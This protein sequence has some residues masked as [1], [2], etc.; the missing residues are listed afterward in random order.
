MIDRS[1]RDKLA[2]L[3]RRLAAGRITT[4]Q[5]ADECEDICCSSEDSAILG[6]LSSGIMQIPWSYWPRRLRNKHRLSDEV[7]HRIAIAVVFLHSECEYEW[8]E[9]TMGGDCLLLAAF[10]LLLVLGAF[11]T[12]FWQLGQVSVFVAVAC[13]ALAVY[14]FYFSNIRIE[15]AR[16]RWLANCKQVGDFD[17]WPFF[18]SSDLERARTPPRFLMG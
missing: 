17:A 16:K 8:P 14:V 10:L 5:F 1:S 13:F 2:L 7:R 11:A 9:D 12:V 4:G 18:R 15:K 3:L 6:I